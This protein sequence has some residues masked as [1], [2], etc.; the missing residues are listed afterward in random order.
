[1]EGKPIGNK[2]ANKKKGLSRNLG[3]DIIFWSLNCIAVPMSGYMTYLGYIEMLNG[4]LGAIAVAVLS[5]LLFFAL[6]MLIRERRLKGKG[7]LVL[8]LGYIVPL[9]LSFFGFFNTTYCNLLA[10]EYFIEELEHYQEVI[11]DNHTFALNVLES[12]M[13]PCEN[14]IEDIEDRMKAVICEFS[15]CNEVKGCG[16]LCNRDLDTLLLKIDQIP[17]DLDLDAFAKGKVIKLRK[18]GEKIKNYEIDEYA[19][20]LRQ[21]VGVITREYELRERKRLNYDRR[22]DTI[23]SFFFQADMFGIDSLQTSI[24]N[25][26]DFDEGHAIFFL[27]NMKKMNNSILNEVVGLGG[28]SE[29]DLEAKKIVDID[30][31]SFR[32]P[33]WTLNHVISV[34][35]PGILIA[36]FL[37]A[38]VIDLAALLFIYLAYNNKPTF[39]EF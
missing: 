26:P 8:L 37:F 11:N 30:A 33:G 24:K 17:Y 9:S 3:Y 36:S 2:Q 15:G 16:D 22:E 29:S 32:N 5:A 27:S 20:L 13:L 14:A 4:Q 10:E 35:R 18:E 39:L 21:K 6:N 1:M 28:Y 34:K 19:K 25:S 12:E 7:T 38:F 31:I 23:N